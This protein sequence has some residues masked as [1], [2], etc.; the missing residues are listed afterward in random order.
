M[1][2]V[3]GPVKKAMMPSSPK[4]NN[5]PPYFKGPGNVMFPGPSY[6]YFLSFVIYL[7]LPVLHANMN[8]TC[9]TA[10]YI[11]PEVYTC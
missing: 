7:M 8:V 1:W 3:S 4:M 9:K 2:F 10:Y 11:L 6:F 5:P